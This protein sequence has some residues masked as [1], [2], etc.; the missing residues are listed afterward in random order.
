M[1]VVSKFI[2]GADGEGNLWLEGLPENNRYP[3]APVP[4]RGTIILLHDS[5][6]DLTMLGQAAPAGSNSLL[7]PDASH[8]WTG[9]WFHEI[10]EP[11]KAWF[12]ERLPAPALNFNCSR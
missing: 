10:A 9:Y 8:Q 4:N 5:T 11:V 12:T 3:L 1:K 2:P 6:N 7:I